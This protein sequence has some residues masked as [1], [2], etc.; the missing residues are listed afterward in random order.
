M[1]ASRTKRRPA[2]GNGSA[3]PTVYD[4]EEAAI[5]SLGVHSLGDL[6]DLEV[7]GEPLDVFLGFCDQH[8]YDPAAAGAAA[9]IW[10]VGV[11]AD[12]RNLCRRALFEFQQRCYERGRVTVEEATSTDGRT[13]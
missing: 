1:A 4:R 11:D 13:I 10:F 3:R 2:T 8:G 12:S 7:Y 6:A 5:P 9:L